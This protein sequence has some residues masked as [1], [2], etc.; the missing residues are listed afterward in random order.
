MELVYFDIISLTLSKIKRNIY[1]GNKYSLQPYTAW[2]QNPLVRTSWCQCMYMYM[3]VHTMAR[4]AYIMHSWKV[5]HTPA[6]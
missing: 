6:T 2:A 3:Y 4:E 1:V 5:A